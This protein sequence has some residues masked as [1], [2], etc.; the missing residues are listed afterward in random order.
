MLLW[1]GR[2]SQSLSTCAMAEP[3]NSVS[4]QSLQPE[5]SA[6]RDVIRRIRRAVSEENAYLIL[7]LI[8]MGFACAT[9]SL[10]LAIW[11]EHEESVLTASHDLLSTTQEPRRS[12]K[13]MGILSVLLSEVNRDGPSAMPQEVE[14]AFEE[15]F[16]E[17]RKTK[18][19]YKLLA[20]Q[21]GDEL[22]GQYARKCPEVSD[23]FRGGYTDLEV[24]EIV[25]SGTL[26][27]DAMSFG[28]GKGIC[29]GDSENGDLITYVPPTFAMPRDADPGTGQLLLAAQHI[30]NVSFEDKVNVQQ[31]YFITPEGLFSLRSRNSKTLDVVYRSPLYDWDSA[32]YFEAF[33][34]PKEN[35]E[36]VT[37][38]VYLDLA[39]LGLVRTHCRLVRG[40]GNPGRK[41]GVLCIDEN[42]SSDQLGLENAASRG[43]FSFVE[44]SVDVSETDAIVEVTPLRSMVQ[45]N[46]QGTLADVAATKFGGEH[47]SLQQQIEEMLL[48]KS[49]SSFS[50]T[51]IPVP[52][53]GYESADPY[54]DVQKWGSDHHYAHLVMVGR[55]DERL[56]FILVAPSSPEESLLALSVILIALG[57]LTTL[58]F[59]ALVRAASSRAERSHEGALL[60]NLQVGVLELSDL[61]RIKFANDR[62]EELLGVPLNRFGQAKIVAECDGVEFYDHIEGIYEVD[63]AEVWASSPAS[64]G[65]KRRHIRSSSYVAMVPKTNV[66]LR[67]HGSSRLAVDTLPKDD[68]PTYGVVE[69]ISESTYESFQSRASGGE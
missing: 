16:S 40:P 36:E 48:G 10:L 37:T 41:L 24:E 50:S 66:Y 1:F 44:F 58:S 4:S 21:A 5:V 17:F 52:L 42:V 28:R 64:V 8:L 12:V 9:S 56:H 7:T 6:A 34:D 23:L 63:G 57:V 25:Y 11:I 61:S 31:T 47:P 33:L 53:S 65:A 55:S 49:A 35:R 32:S 62:A 26:A 54:G 22:S 19:N 59:T 14:D 68:V 15:F 18:Q 38:L 69:R 3:S 2:R 67:V 27:I 39:G 60:R 29:V 30:K 20:E 46:G 43:L 45:A 13:R 51:V